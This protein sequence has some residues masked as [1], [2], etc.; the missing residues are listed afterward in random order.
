MYH[1]SIPTIALFRLYG[2]H[3]AEPLGSRQVVVGFCKQLEFEAV[4]E[5]VNDILGTT[6]PGNA[7]CLRMSDL[8]RLR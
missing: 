3:L 5:T 2:L 6:V 7:D 8:Y 1:K 4:L